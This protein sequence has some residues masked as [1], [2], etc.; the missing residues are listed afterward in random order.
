MSPYNYVTTLYPP[1]AI[2][3][4]VK[5]S[6]L[7]PNYTHIVTS[8]SSQIELWAIAHERLVFLQQHAISGNIVVLETVSHP[9]G[10][11]MLFL[12]TDNGECCF[13]YF[14]DK[15]LK[16]YANGCFEHPSLTRRQPDA[17]SLVT[18]TGPSETD[19]SVIV[20]MYAGVLVA[21]P[22]P[23]AEGDPIDPFYASIN[24]SV[25]HSIVD[26]GLD[27]PTIAVLYTNE[28]TRCFIQQYHV[29]S[30]GS[31]IE[32][33]QNIEVDKK[34]RRLIPFPAPFKGILAIG[35]MIIN[36]LPYGSGRFISNSRLRNSIQNV[37]ITTAILLDPENGNCLVGTDS[38]DLYYI[39]LKKI[40][41]NVHATDVFF[42]PIGKT[43]A[44]STMVYLGDG[45]LFQGSIHGD[46]YLVKVN[47]YEVTKHRL[48]V[49]DSL[50][51]L[52]PMTDFCTYSRGGNGQDVMVCCTGHRHN[53][54]LQ[55][56]SNGHDFLQS[57][58]IPN[59][60]AKRIFGLDSHNPTL[61][62]SLSDRTLL[63]GKSS[64]GEMTSLDSLAGFQLQEETVAAALIGKWFAQVTP[65][66]II[67]GDVPV[68]KPEERIRM[69]HIVGHQ[70]LLCHG[71]HEL[72]YFVIQENHIKY[73]R[74]TRFD[75]PIVSLIL[76]DAT[77]GMSPF[78]LVGLSSPESIVQMH[79][80][81]DLGMV[82]KRNMPSGT[83]PRSLALTN[84]GFHK[85][86]AF[87]SLSNGT[88]LYYDVDNEQLVSE[89]QVT[90]GLHSATLSTLII[91]GCKVVFAT[92]NETTV[93]DFDADIGKLQFTTC[94]LTDIQAVAMSDCPGGSALVCSTAKGLLFGQLDPM[95]KPQVSTYSLDGY[96]PKK[97]ARHDKSDTLIIGAS[98]MTRNYGNGVESYASRLF[99]MDAMT[100]HHREAHEL[101]PNEVPSSIAVLNLK[102]HGMD[103]ACVGTIFCENDTS[104]APRGR[105]LMYEILPS[106]SYRLIDAAELPTPVWDIKSYLDTVVFSSGAAIF[107][108]ENVNPKNKQGERLQ[109]KCKNF[110]DVECICL[111]TQGDTVLVGDIMQSVQLLQSSAKD[112]SLKCIAKDSEM[113]W[114]TALQ[115]M[116]DQLLLTADQSQY[117]YIKQPVAADG[118]VKTLGRYHLGDLVNTFKRKSVGHVG[119]SFPSN[120]EIQALPDMSTYTYYCTARGAIGA[121]IPISREKY[122]VLKELQKK[123]LDALPRLAYPSHLNWRY[124]DS[125]DT[126]DPYQ[127]F[128]DGDVVEQFMLMSADS[129]RNIVQS[130]KAFP[131][132]GAITALL[133]DLAQWRCRL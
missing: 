17:L 97:I 98:K 88:M 100:F 21:V 101:F 39:G 128:I 28:H 62:I 96:V 122:V 73:I 2:S 91:H 57:A 30:S 12:V 104:D 126:I 50:P 9:D 29:L 45:L 5:G 33:K 82:S 95:V 124:P 108:L 86:Y 67:L 49:C 117:L 92:S 24:H 121:V 85:L 22:V 47:L 58:Q 3:N 116:D 61:V 7:D 105:F 11:D 36:Y 27:S 43:T 76:A 19:L 77:H 20:S 110:S 48:H 89:R 34:M 80:L 119:M 71:E 103:V 42:E 123:L 16:L 70:I 14:T 130:S 10:K 79:S 59:L 6:F 54:A 94:N 46:S 4:S 60:S 32:P 93:I 69:A 131:S 25:V 35:N 64:E 18:R 111:D 40:P 56:V 81:P 37:G 83:T 38:G 102:D 72:L 68:W 84:F 26:L 8:K 63:L 51:S 66:Q 107:M 75:I 15:E 113:R 31:K 55:I 90:L 41:G 112:A 118:T 129:R 74:A 120:G 78:A 87:V 65:T 115:I 109:V 13:L 132:V 99:I 23:Q 106:G 44:P 114:T 125:G 133:Q 1:T 52:S 127:G 53:G